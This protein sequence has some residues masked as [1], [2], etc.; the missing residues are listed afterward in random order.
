MICWVRPPGGMREALR[1]ASISKL[2]SRSNKTEL[3]RQIKQMPTILLGLKILALRAGRGPR[4]GGNLWGAARYSVA[5]QF[6]ALAMSRQESRCTAQS[7]TFSELTSSSVQE[8][9]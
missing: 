7:L 5:R 6:A 4:G 9:N 1:L 3:R 2:L 8:K